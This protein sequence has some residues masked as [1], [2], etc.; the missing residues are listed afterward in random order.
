MCKGAYGDISMC[1]GKR[2]AILFNFCDIVT[3]KIVRNVRVL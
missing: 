2:D 1:R 3:H